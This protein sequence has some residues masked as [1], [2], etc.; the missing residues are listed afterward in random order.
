MTAVTNNAATADAARGLRVPQLTQ[1]TR[2]ARRSDARAHRLH[3][4]RRVVHRAV[5]SVDAVS[6]SSAGAADG[7]PAARRAGP[8]ARAVLLSAANCRSPRTPFRRGSRAPRAARSVRSWQG[9]RSR[10]RRARPVAVARLGQIGPRPVFAARARRAA[11]ARRRGDCRDRRDP[12]RRVRR[13]ARRLSRRSDRSRG[14][15]DFRAGARPA[16]ALCDAGVSLD[17]SDRASDDHGLHSH[18]HPHGRDWMACR[19]ARRKDDRHNG[20]NSRL[21]HG[22]ARV[23]RKSVAAARSAHT[24]GDARILTRAGARAHS[25][26]DSG[27]DDAVVCGIGVRGGSPELGHAAAG[28]V[29]HSRDGRLSVAAE[30]GRGDHPGGAGG[31]PAARA[32]TPSARADSR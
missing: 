25:F 26:R 30:R 3:R 22:G 23:G 29:G 21:C 24:S 16:R 4:D 11:V 1:L 12:D 9:D 6:R 14:H 2:I 7:A 8:V 28:G 15:E 10:D 27:G 18:D 20:S 13:R 32:S 19:R 31:Q 5:R 17:T